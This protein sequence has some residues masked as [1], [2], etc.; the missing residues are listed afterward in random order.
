MTDPDRAAR[1]STLND[2]EFPDDGPLAGGDV[3]RSNDPEG[4]TAR[5]VSYADDGIP[6]IAD[7][8]RPEDAAAENPEFAPLPGDRRHEPVSFGTTAAEQSEGESLDQRLA[9]EV[10]DAGS[11]DLSEVRAAEHHDRTVPQI[12]QNSDTEPGASSGSDS[13]GDDVVASGEDP[14]GGEG[15]EEKA[16]HLTD[17]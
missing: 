2:A 5:D 13:V 8:S 3:L 12:D 15:P 10:P 14:T 6:E 7:D 16:M 17:G 11:G 9:E 1:D 4:Q